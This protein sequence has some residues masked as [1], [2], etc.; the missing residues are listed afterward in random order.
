[1]RRSFG[2]IVKPRVPEKQQMSSV[3]VVYFGMEACGLS[4]AAKNPVEGGRCLNL[5]LESGFSPP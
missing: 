1:M 2:S 3:F 4:A 5:D